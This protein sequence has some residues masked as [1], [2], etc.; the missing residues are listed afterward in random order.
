MKYITPEFENIVLADAV[1]MNTS[2][3]PNKPLEDQVFSGN[4]EK[5]V[6]DEGFEDDVK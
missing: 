4:G 1:I 2:L 6:L 3:D 5:N